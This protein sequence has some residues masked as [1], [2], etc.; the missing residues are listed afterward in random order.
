MEPNRLPS[1]Q[2]K[3]N[4]F[5]LLSITA[6]IFALF[7]CVSPPMQLLFGATA[8][9]MAYISKNNERSLPVPAFVGSLLGIAGIFCSFAVLGLYV[10]TIRMLDDPGYVAMHREFMRQ[11]QDMINSFPLK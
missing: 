1:P 9:M 4:F 3:K 8:L 5:S 7:A 10:M 6:G 11:Y 2:N